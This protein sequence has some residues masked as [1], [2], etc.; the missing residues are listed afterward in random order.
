[1][2]MCSHL[3]AEHY[4]KLLN[5]CLKVRC[6]FDH[7]YFLLLTE[8]TDAKNFVHGERYNQVLDAFGCLLYLVGNIELHR[9]FCAGI[10][11]KDFI[12][13]QVCAD[14]LM[15]CFRLVIINHTF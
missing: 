14:I 8:P 13:S 7:I 9:Y 10:F 5:I 2:R 15:L 6:R 4:N 12:T 3:L 11:Q 1:M